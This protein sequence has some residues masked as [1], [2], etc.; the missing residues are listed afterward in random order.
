M[1][2]FVMVLAENAGNM[3]VDRDSFKE[4][5]FAHM[6]KLV[7]AMQAGTTT[8]LDSKNLSY[9]M[10]EA[11]T[12]MPGILP[13][14]LQGSQAGE[15][16]TT[17]QTMLSIGTDD[18][19]VRKYDG[20]L[21][22]HDVRKAGLEL[23]LLTLAD[24]L[25]ACAENT[26]DPDVACT[27]TALLFDA[28]TQS[29]PRT[30]QNTGRF[31]T[32]KLPEIIHAAVQGTAKNP[33]TGE[34]CI[35]D[36]D[37]GNISYKPY[38]P[39][40]VYITDE[41]H[42]IACY[43]APDQRGQILELFQEAADK[44]QND[45][46][47]AE[48]HAEIFDSFTS[49]DTICALTDLPVNKLLDSWCIGYGTTERT[50]HADRMTDKE[51]EIACAKRIVSLETQAPGICNDLYKKF[52]IRN[53]ARCS[54]KALLRQYYN[55]AKDYAERIY[56]LSGTGDNNGSAIY[57]SMPKIEKAIAQLD[58][59]GIGVFIVEASTRSDLKV[60]ASKARMAGWGPVRYIFV[61]LHG[62]FDQI[63]LGKEFVDKKDAKQWLG[64]LIAEITID[65]DIVVLN[66][67]NTGA[68]DTGFAGTL[69]RASGREIHGTRAGTWLKELVVATDKT[70]TPQVTADIRYSKKWE[71]TEGEPI[72]KFGKQL[73][74]PDKNG[75]TPGEILLGT[76]H[77]IGQLYNNIV[78]V[79]ESLPIDGLRVA[80]LI[81]HDCGLDIRSASH[82]SQTR[83][84]EDI[85]YTTVETAENIDVIRGKLVEAAKQLRAY[86]HD[87]TG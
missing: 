8:P 30:Q 28:S 1:K 63:T 31:L 69:Q 67:C 57:N 73:R 74:Q 33:V 45:P 12:M 65:E 38:Y 81:L 58:A 23:T 44:A 19:I 71:D 76:D 82:G 49:L 25:I 87:I 6:C 66:A 64:A 21:S 41:L 2:Y 84:L 72:R 75:N 79:L 68:E 47:W 9:E 62:D 53:F 61:D 77:T 35:E 80:S 13:A 51:Y 27:A 37:S 17:L 52:G 15:A 59:H 18:D 10:Q 42:R 20:C 40:L 70:G 26:N 24:T 60:L 39:S 22:K 85:Y 29:P 36:A 54:E 46:Y 48:V 78:S 50:D 14:A 3:Y 86:L 56:V 32:S 83:T 16:I 5:L 34:Y 43:A 7:E 55:Q 11:L 4:P